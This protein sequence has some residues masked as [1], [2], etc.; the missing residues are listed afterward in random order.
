MD[1]GH[2]RFDDDPED[3]QL[4]VAV[5]ATTERSGTGEATVAGHVNVPHRT[6]DHG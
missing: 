4:M 5:N 2:C 3:V 1:I 6:D